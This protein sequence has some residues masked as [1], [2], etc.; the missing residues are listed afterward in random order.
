M[1]KA[2]PGSARGMKRLIAL[3]LVVL[4]LAALT[5][6][7][8]PSL[9]RSRELA[10]RA[11]MRADASY[12]QAIA[13]LDTD[14]AAQPTPRAHVKSLPAKERFGFVQ[15]AISSGDLATVSAVVNAQPFLSGLKPEELGQVRIIAAQTFAAEAVAQRKAVGALV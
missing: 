11:M 9:Q 10:K 6:V 3:V 2:T 15:S 5:S 13:E 14:K 4:A 7:L 12:D 1:E 8:M